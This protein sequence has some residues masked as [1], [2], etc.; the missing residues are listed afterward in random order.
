MQGKCSSLLPSFPPPVM[1]KEF[2]SD[3]SLAGCNTLMSGSLGLP[4]QHSRADSGGIGAG[5]LPEGQ[6]IGVLSLLPADGSI[7]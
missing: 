3:A 4:G 7:E 5:E 1:V 2:G 6:R